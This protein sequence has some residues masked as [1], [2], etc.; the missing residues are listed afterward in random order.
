MELEQPFVLLY[1]LLDSPCCLHDPPA[2]VSDG[3]PSNY[4][5]FPSVLGLMMSLASNGVYS[6]FTGLGDNTVITPKKSG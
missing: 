3:F 6:L 5:S 2:A 1:P 4:G